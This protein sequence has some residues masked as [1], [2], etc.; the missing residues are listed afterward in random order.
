MAYPSNDALATNYSGQDD[1][2][3]AYILKGNKPLDLFEHEVRDRLA[4]QA[5]RKTEVAKAAQGLD[6]SDLGEKQVLENH[7]P[8]LMNQVNGFVKQRADFESY[9]NKHPKEVGSEKYAQDYVTLQQAKNNITYKAQLSA[10]ARAKREKESEA[11]SNSE[12]GTYDP[13]EMIGYLA[14]Y[15]TTKFNDVNGLSTLVQGQAP[16]KS[17]NYDQ[18]LLTFTNG[19]AR[20]TVTTDN[21]GLKT[22]TVNKLT[23]GKGQ[24]TAYKTDVVD[25]QITQF[26][27]TEK[28]KAA[29]QSKFKAGKE[30]DPGYTMEDAVADFHN[31]AYGKI[32]QSFVQDRERAPAGDK[33]VEIAKIGVSDG[34]DI[35][36]SVNMMIGGRN[37]S[38]IQDEADAKKKKA[39]K[40][41]KDAKTGPEIK[42]AQ[43]ELG[44][45][46]KSVADAAKLGDAVKST[47]F[48]SR[49]TK[50]FPT[51]KIKYASDKH[52]NL[53]TGKE[54]DVPGAIDYELSSIDEL[55]YTVDKDGS[56]ILVRD[57]IAK[58]ETTKKGVKYGWFAIGEQSAGSKG[59]EEVHLPVA[60]PVTTE[61]LD[62]VNESNKG[63]VEKLTTDDESY[64]A[65]Q[66]ARD[67]KTGAYVQLGLKDGKWYNVETGKEVQ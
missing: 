10:T 11:L 28:G 26:L 52:I 56:K 54:E 8:E 39:D 27:T 13:N 33:P 50:T 51:T 32:D 42:A 43:L 12:P 64:Q 45:A 37:I 62:Q 59:G 47:S 23:D 48:V 21:G 25:P 41:V 6:V 44:A 4:D 55:P 18:N 14:G 46:N 67:K 35:G 30:S 29:L 61:L 20:K 5:K 15:G 65:I 24:P 16:Q 34:R 31:D 7:V 38:D 2:G 3:G 22:T 57:K 36:G 53:E 49:K 60:V 9:Y 19:I 17:Y 40:M 58:G 63:K 66:K 1:A